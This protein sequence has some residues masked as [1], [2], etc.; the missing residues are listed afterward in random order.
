[1]LRLRNFTIGRKLED[2]EITSEDS[3]ENIANLVE[4]MVPFVSCPKPFLRTPL[5]HSLKLPSA[6][7]E[8]MLAKCCAVGT[9]ITYLNSVVMPDRN[10]A[11]SSDDD[12]DEEEEEEE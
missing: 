9:Q 4:S 7:N 8:G 11:D 3:L 6:A 12:D 2:S 10:A 1:L 5:L